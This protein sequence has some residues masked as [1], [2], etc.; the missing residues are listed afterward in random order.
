MTNLLDEPTSVLEKKE[1]ELLFSIVR[2]LRE[3]AS[4]VFH[5]ARLEEVLDIS[6]RVY[7][8]RDGKCVKELPAHGATVKD[9][10]GLMVG[11]QLHHEYYRETRQAQPSQQDRAGGRGTSAGRRVPECDLR[12]S[13]GR[14]SGIAGVIVRVARNW[15]AVF[16]PRP[17]PCRQADHQR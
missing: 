2:S 1:V 15:R 12:A 7:V 5:L 4:F 16:R 13:C 8:L 11:R 6:D 17:P 3:R 9:L 14:G 10:H